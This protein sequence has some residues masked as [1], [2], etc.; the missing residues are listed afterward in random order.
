MYLSFPYFILLLIFFDHALFQVVFFLLMYFSILFLVQKPR[1]HLPSHLIFLV[2][3]YLTMDFKVNLSN[4]TLLIIFITYETLPIFF[5][6]LPQEGNVF[7]ELLN[8][9]GNIDKPSKKLVKII[10]IFTYHTFS[11][12]WR[13]SHFIHWLRFI[14][15][16]SSSL[17]EAKN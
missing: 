17:K 3:F 6:F 15:K 7:D 4:F 2:L 16:I 11:Y 12:S 14:K 5:L 8:I 1:M 9:C 10:N 13:K